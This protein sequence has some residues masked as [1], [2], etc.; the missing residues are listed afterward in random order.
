VA[1]RTPPLS[2]VYV[3]VNSDDPTEGVGAPT[4]LTFAAV[5]FDVPQE[6]TASGVDDQELDGDVAYTLVLSATTA[7]P[8][9]AT[10]DPPDVSATNLDDESDETYTTDT[11][12]VTDTTDSG[13][14]TETTDTT[15]PGPDGTTDGGGD[16]KGGGCGCGTRG[17]PWG[18]LGGFGLV[19]LV[20]RRRRPGRCGV[21]D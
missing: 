5:D 3:V 11:G 4:V 19:A 7:D 14:D 1:L 16:D 12:T 13:S 20:A 6:V 2:E 21:G 15:D 8:I 10:I 18:G 17:S 9:Y